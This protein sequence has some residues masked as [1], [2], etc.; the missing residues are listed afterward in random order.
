MEKIRRKVELAKA[1]P[2]RANG[3]F[4]RTGTPQLA[5]KSYVHERL[6]AMGVPTHIEGP[7]S[8]AGCRVGDRLDY[9]EAALKRL[10]AIENANG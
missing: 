1:A 5:F 7:H 6:D 9:V 10:H 3:T 8:A 4:A 2:R